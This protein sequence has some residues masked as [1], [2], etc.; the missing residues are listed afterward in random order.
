MRG[1]LFDKPAVKLLL[2]ALMGLMVA[3][4]LFKP[5]ML[6]GDDFPGH[7]SYAV[8]LDRM[9]GEGVWYPRWSPN[10]A[11]G[12]GLPTFNFY[13]P[14]P[15]Y[16]SV[17]VHWLGLP[18]REAVKAPM[19]LALMLAGPAMYLFAR[20]IYGERAG[21][22]AGIAFAFAPYLAD[23]ALQRYALNEA[24]AMSLAPLVLWAFGRLN[25]H[26]PRLP[27]GR[28][29]VAALVA[30]ALILTHTLMA[31]MFA[32]LVAGY[33]LL[34]W[35]QSDQR[36]AFL[37]G[38][39][40]AGVLA[41]GLS[42][43]FWLPFI[44]ESGQV[45][46][47]RARVWELTG[48]V[49]YPLHFRSLESV[50][51]PRSL[52]PDYSVSNS[53]LQRMLALPQVICAVIAL[54]WVRR[55]PSQLA[56][57]M[58]MLFG[59]VLVVSTF[60]ILRASKPVWDTLPAL[61]IVQFP[62]RFLGPASLAAALLTGALWS[63]LKF[64]DSNFKWVVV[65]LDAVLLVVLMAWTLPWLR[66]FTCNIEANPS[67]Q[68]LVW[69]DRK[70]ESGGGTGEDLPRWVETPPSES[71]LE[72]DLIA[73]R[74]LDRLDRASLPEG[75]QA[76]ARVLRSLDSTWEVTSPKTFTATFQNYYFPGWTVKVDG[77]PVPVSPAPSTG[78][79]EA[80][81]PAG[82]D[83]VVLLLEATPAQTLGDVISTVTLLGL[84]VLL[85]VTNRKTITL[86][87]VEALAG[88][89][90]GST[91]TSSQSDMPK[92]ITRPGVEA[93]AGPLQ[94]STPTSPRDVPAW[95]WMA[96]G[97]IGV[98]LFVVRLALAGVAPPAVPDG[99]AIPATVTRTSV[100]LSGQTQLI[101]Y[102]FS[103]PTVRAGEPLTV[104]LY[105]QAQRLLLTS[106]K[107]FVH[108][109]DANG[110]LVAQ[111]DAVPR[112][113][114]YPTSAWFPNERVVDP[115]VMQIPAGVPGPLEV[116]AGMYDPATG[117][118]LNPAADPS[119]RVRLGTLSQ[120]V[121]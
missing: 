104:T 44:V 56:R 64:Q 78:L 9:W 99:L 73:G 36:R 55:L 71:L 1:T 75:A 119:G 40:L 47:W 60:L 109:T 33:L 32:P 94:G 39:A 116:W 114:T 8:E 46:M 24:L 83:V 113:W 23:D 121:P 17:A 19:A 20:A 92:T 16:V 105:W 98:V 76:Q 107:S 81:L 101:G 70:T 62:W 118:R 30:S 111:G 51:W 28:V 48:E 2:L 77:M 65:A 6:C 25:A 97:A 49:L 100:D 106:Y 18:L 86:P 120:S 90:Q 108:V 52:W 115:H 27:W 31:M 42:A 11:F 110:Q 112:N 10:V 35:W 4:P 89:P 66:P 117:Q 91:P 12:L 80:S 95:E 22:V 67:G 87:G 82:H 79:I 72:A 103:S 74:P 58:T 88:P 26:S 15:R 34:V 85:V 54:V 57:A 61:Q 7:L 43:F 69:M 45:Q 13:P 3:A 96:L 59:L 84:V 63:N 68:F 38:V 5:A 29:V 53:L 93:L 37:G 41:L 21:M 50:L 14:L 102:E